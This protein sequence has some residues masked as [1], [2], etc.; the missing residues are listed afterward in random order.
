MAAPPHPRRPL[1]QRYQDFRRAYTL[2]TLDQADDETPKTG[3]TEPGYIAVW[4]GAAIVAFPLAVIS[5]EAGHWLLARWFGF[6]DAALHYGS[7]SYAT[8]SQFW[9]LVRAGD[10]AGAG[11]VHPVWQ[12]A[13]VAGGGLI[14]SYLTV[15]AAGLYVR[16]RG[17]TPFISAL[18]IIAALRFLGGIP[19]LGSR[20]LGIAKNPS[21]DETRV[22]MIS[23]VPEWVWL[24]AGLGAF[25]FIVRTVRRGIP[26]ASR[27]RITL[28]L[29][30]GIVAGA[31]LYAQ[32]AGPALLP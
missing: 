1:K 31:V 14:V 28:W 25:W 27:R 21:S 19:L 10:L 29:G 22:A 26:E 12:P 9:D 15:L 7:A 3:E 20:F 5:H 11:A 4:P 18:G 8:S 30:A 13:L 17:A 24:V 2:G 32:V 16:V 6:P 23:G